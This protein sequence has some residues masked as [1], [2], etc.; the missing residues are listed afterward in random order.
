MSKIVR[1]YSKLAQ[2]YERTATDHFSIHMVDY[3]WQIMKRLRYHP[4]SVLDLCCGTGTAACLFAK[5]GL[6]TIGLDGSREMLRVAR[7]KA[8]QKKLRIRFVGRRLPRFYIKTKSGKKLQL[9]DLI[10]CFYDSLNYLLKENDLKICFQS[11]RKHLAPGGLFVF[12]M[13]TLFGL[14]YI[15]PV[16]THTGC[17]ED[18]AW[19]WRA[20]FNDRK[21]IADMRMVIFAKKGRFWERFDEIHRERAYENE[22][23]IKML[24]QAG[25]HVLGFY[26]CFKFRKP[27]VRAGRIAVVAKRM[28]E[29]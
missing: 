22:T 4:K 17:H 6:D 23:I 21:K 24:E 26:R 16:R 15:W 19:I 8:T 29:S 28:I 1:P 13:N 11:V 12:D 10:T 9:F 27:G 7:T 5:K 3:T 18:L 14:K 20:Q 2:Y 25:L